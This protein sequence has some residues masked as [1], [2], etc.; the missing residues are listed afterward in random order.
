MVQP[1]LVPKCR[2]SKTTSGLGNESGWV[3]KM[4]SYILNVD[5]FYSLRKHKASFMT[6]H[7]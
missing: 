4:T 3:T 2:R 1:F 6:T 5:Q 7:M